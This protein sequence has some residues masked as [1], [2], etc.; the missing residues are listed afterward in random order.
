MRASH[1]GRAKSRHVVFELYF[2]R[3]KFLDCFFRRPKS[4]NIFFRAKSQHTHF[5]SQWQHTFLA[6]HKV[7]KYLFWV[8]QSRANNSV[9]QRCNIPILRRNGR[10]IN[11]FGR[12][13]SPKVSSVAQSRNVL[14]LICNDCNLS[15]LGRNGRKIPLLSGNGRNISPRLRSGKLSKFHIKLTICDIIIIL[16]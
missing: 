11:C 13:N 4:H 1:F 14:I 10:N 2:N 5:K 16:I 6:P 9:A 7:A 15:N 3:P 12:A 8:T